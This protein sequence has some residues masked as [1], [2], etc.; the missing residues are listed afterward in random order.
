MS[1]ADQERDLPALTVARIF[2][3]ELPHRIHS[4]QIY[5]VIAPNGST[6]IVYG[7]DRGLRILWRGGRRR[8]EDA[9]SARRPRR[10]GTASG[11]DVIVIDDDDEE[12]Q[13]NAQSEQSNFEED[14]DEQDPDC[15]YPGVIQA[16]DLDLDAEVLHLAIPPVSYTHL[17]LPTKRIV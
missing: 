1:S 13:Q 3:Y 11:G 10:N 9:Q 7:H 16:V 8:K 6:V 4:A 5:P 2:S 15:P 14:E 12:P 17:T